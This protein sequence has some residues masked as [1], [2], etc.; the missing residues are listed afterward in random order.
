MERSSTKIHKI[1]LFIKIENTATQ[2]R[3]KLKI[4]IGIESG[5]ITFMVEL[6]KM[7]FP[8]KFCINIYQ[9]KFPNSIKHKEIKAFTTRNFILWKSAFTQ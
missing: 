1:L 3:Y 6:V 8:S 7:C 9:N 5:R 4:M 2:E